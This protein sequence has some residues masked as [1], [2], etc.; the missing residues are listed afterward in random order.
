M[1][2]NP[3]KPSQVN[4]QLFYGKD[5]MKTAKDIA[6]DLALYGESSALVGGRRMG[7]STLLFKIKEELSS[8][9]TILPYYVD[10]QAR[11]ELK[12]SDSSF[13]WLGTYAGLNNS[14]YADFGR[15]LRTKWMRDGGC[16]RIVFLIDEFDLFG[17]YDWHG[18]FFD[19]LRS[20]LTNNPEAREYI[21][22]VVAGPKKLESLLVEGDGS[23]LGSALSWRYLALLDEEDSNRLVNEP[24]NGAVTREGQAGIFQKT[25]GHPYFIQSLMYRLHGVTPDQF[26]LQLTQA[27]KDFLNRHEGTLRGWWENQLNSD[28]RAVFSLLLANGELSKRE[29]KTSLPEVAMSDA[30]R[31]LSYNG[32]IRIGGDESFGVVSSMLKQWV[33]NNS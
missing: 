8:Y 16:S 3:Y 28:E 27:E 21:A 30:L 17:T 23:P 13:A 22:I 2:D 1:L 5:R 31:V 10:V 9:K 29:L 7:K 6:A 4:L 24:T 15:C 32:F 18:H 25:G 11:T 26:L 19:N 14:G 20:L 12:S 33:S